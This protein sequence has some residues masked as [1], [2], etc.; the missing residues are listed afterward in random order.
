MSKGPSIRSHRGSPS[1]AQAA[2]E[3]YV[4]LLDGDALGVD[5]AEIRI[6]KEVD[7]EGFSGFLEGHDG[8]ALPSAGTVLV[9]DCLGYLADLGGC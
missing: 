1:C 9:C 3:L 7:E 6:M 4:L 8:L 5:G 2:G